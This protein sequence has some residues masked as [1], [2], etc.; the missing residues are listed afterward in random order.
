MP[1]PPFEDLIVPILKLLKDGKTHELQTLKESLVVRFGV[2]PA[3]RE[4]RLPSTLTVRVFDN[5]VLWAIQHLK[6][7]GL[8][9]TPK[10]AVYQLTPLGSKLAA[11]PPAR[12]DRPYLISKFPMATAYFTGLSAASSSATLPTIPS[13]PAPTRSAPVSTAETPQE[14][15]EGAVNE[16]HGKLVADL[17]ERLANCDPALYETI[18]SRLLVRMGYALSEEDILQRHGKPGDGGIDGRV[19]RD[20]LGLEQVYVQAK[21]WSKPVPLRPIVDFSDEVNRSGVRKGVFVARSGFNSDA[22]SWID[23][24]KHPERRASIAWIDGRRLAE[25]MVL[26]GIGVRE[27]GTYILKGV[28]ENL[29]ESEGV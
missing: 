5:R 2:T 1:I 26:H 23:D 22:Q 21:R 19:Q 11:S 13:P 10:R 29:F 7:A 18:I 17:V 3:E 12:I 25:L 9:I 8:L 24:P 6:I 20:P 4:L 16:V 15:I 27:S 14:R 28:D